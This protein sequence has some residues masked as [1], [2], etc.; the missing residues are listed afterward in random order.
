MKAFIAAIAKTRQLLTVEI[1]DPVECSSVLDHI[2]R[3][4]PMSL[5]N[6]K[7]VEKAKDEVDHGDPEKG[8]T[9]LGMINFQENP[10]VKGSVVKYQDGW[11][12]VTARFK[13]TVNLGGIFNGK[14][15]HKHVPL[16]EVFEDHDA[17]YKNWQESETYKSM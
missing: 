9:L 3:I 4:I 8:D 6:Q 1:H 5:G 10:V 11:V 12:R 14:I 2:L 13:H 17:W 15:Y 16:G 7:L